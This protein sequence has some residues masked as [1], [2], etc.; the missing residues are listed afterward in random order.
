MTISFSGN[1]TKLIL[2]A[3]AVPVVVP[4]WT[5]RAAAGAAEAVQLLRAR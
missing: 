3:G 1:G 2:F 5:L 4:A